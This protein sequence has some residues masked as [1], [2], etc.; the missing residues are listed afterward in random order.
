MVQYI[1]A[2]ETEIDGED[3]K[4][5]IAKLC[6]QALHYIEKLDLLVQAKGLRRRVFR[7]WEVRANSGER[8]DHRCC[9]HFSADN[10]CVSE[11]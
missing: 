6:A 4:I 7:F 1:E 11:Y 8:E 9:R 10:S 5:E 3:G 2:R